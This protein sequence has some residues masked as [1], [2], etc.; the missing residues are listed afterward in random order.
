MFEDSQRKSSRRIAPI[1]ASF[2]LHCLVLVIL[3]TRGPIFVKPSS[4]AWGQHGTSESV[5]Y[6]PRQVTAM[7]SEAPLRELP[8]RPNRPAKDKFEESAKAASENGSAFRAPL[9][10]TEAIPAIPLVFPDPSIFAWQ[11]PQGLQGD[12]VVEITIDERGSVTDARLLQSLKGGNCH[13]TELAVHARQSGRHRDQ[14]APG[15][16][17]PLPELANKIIQLIGSSLHPPRRVCA[18]VAEGS[19]KTLNAAGPY[20]IQR[21]ALSV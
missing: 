14:L 8:K 10:G 19:E 21:R 13:R 12:V 6:F 3:W 11:L 1:V 9:T 18:R 20:H 2:L 16:A 17:L 15:Y 4:L 5:L 7:K